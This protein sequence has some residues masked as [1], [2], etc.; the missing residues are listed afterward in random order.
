MENF[1][2][3]EKGRLWF[4]A[5]KRHC[6]ALNTISTNIQQL[7]KHVENFEIYKGKKCVEIFINNIS[8]N[9]QAIKKA[10]EVTSL[11]L[12]DIYKEIEAVIT[13]NAENNE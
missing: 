3:T 11:S 12:T 1:F 2:K 13:K 5:I 9:I 10:N 6:E 7:D 8:K 4:Q